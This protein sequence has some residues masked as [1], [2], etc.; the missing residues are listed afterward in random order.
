M[1]YLSIIMFV[2]S[3]NSYITNEDLIENIRAFC[4]KL[5][6]V[7]S[8]INANLL[9]SANEASTF[10]DI[11][12]MLYNGMI[13]FLPQVLIELIENYLMIYLFYN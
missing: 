10:D 1:S 11:G 13:S 8:Q 3:E 9:A 12:T 4:K 7:K 6:S 2:T 5:D